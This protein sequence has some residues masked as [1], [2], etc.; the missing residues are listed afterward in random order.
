M[1][2][3]T[4]TATTEGGT[5][6]ETGTFTWTL[7]DPCLDGALISTESQG[8]YDDD[9]SGMTETF[10][11]IPFTLTRAICEPRVSYAC[12]S[13]TATDSFTKTLCTGSEDV[14]MDG[15]DLLANY[16]ELYPFTTA[17]LPA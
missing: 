3:F 1:Y 5:T 13:V 14:K 10:T 7:T 12:T 15:I 8:T 9:Y 4:I 16:A 2:T 11:L 6:T 17:T